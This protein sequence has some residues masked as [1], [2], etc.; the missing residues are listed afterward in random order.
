M[1]ARDARALLADAIPMLETSGA[2]VESA[3]DISDPLANAIALL[4]R[5]EIGEPEDVRDR[6]REATTAIGRV[7][8][9]L[10][11]TDAESGLDVVGPFVARSLAILHPIRVELEAELS[12][13]ASLMST[14]PKTSP[15]P[16]LPVHERLPTHERRSAARVRIDAEIGGHSR[17]QFFRGRAGDVSSGGIFVATTQ[18]L[19][20][21]T[22]LTVS[23]VL[24]NG[25]Q[26]VVD[27]AVAW[28]R[29]PNAGVEGMGIRFTS[30][31][32]AVRTALER[33]IG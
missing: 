4:F 11:A 12:R 30:M 16:R 29:G 26:V 32:P 2:D 20:V 6:L 25:D 21:G 19:A 14:G 31:S 8:E 24:S 15:A 3:Q 5:T 28:V 18:P 1:A 33:F 23:L 22:Q 10:N 9:A 13:D 17:S 27:G 7:L